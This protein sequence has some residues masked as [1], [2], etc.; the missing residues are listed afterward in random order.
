MARIKGSTL[1]DDG[2]MEMYLSGMN[3]LQIANNLNLERCTIWQWRKRRGLPA[4][5]RP[6]GVRR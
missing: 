4:N 2:R 5:D 1:P 3:D 6:G